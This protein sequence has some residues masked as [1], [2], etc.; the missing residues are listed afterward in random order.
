MSRLLALILLLL[1]ALAGAD[2]P[3]DCQ[4]YQ[5][6]LTRTA[7]AEWGLNAPISIF[8]AQMRAESACNREQH[9]PQHGK[10]LRTTTRQSRES[11]DP[12]YRLRIN[13]TPEHAVLLNPLQSPV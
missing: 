6:L 5:R 11:L 1:P 4:R 12:S 9:I 2:I 10:R 3:P 7:Q 13:R 8:A